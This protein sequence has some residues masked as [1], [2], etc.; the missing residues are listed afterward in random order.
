MHTI[1]IKALQLK[2]SLMEDEIFKSQMLTLIRYS[3]GRQAVPVMIPQFAKMLV[4][5]YK[6]YAE[7]QFSLHNAHPRVVWDVIY[8]V[9]SKKP[10]FD[11]TVIDIDEI[12]YNYAQ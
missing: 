10:G 2:L 12:M 8:A 1:M 4:K 9:E 3:T 7:G 6:N 11:Q 5:Q